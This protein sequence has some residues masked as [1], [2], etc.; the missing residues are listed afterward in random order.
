MYNLKHQINIQA[1]IDTVF[2]ALVT[3]NGLS[4]WWTA[5]VEAKPEVG[6]KAEFGFFDRETVF[7]MN[8]DKITSELI[9]N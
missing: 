7:T 8:I 5:D 1:D 9:D 3:K 2:K 4:S 6:S